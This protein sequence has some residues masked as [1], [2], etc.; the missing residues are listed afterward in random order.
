MPNYGVAQ[1]GGQLTCV[2]PGDPF[3]LFNA[4]TPTP[5]QASVAFNRGN[6]PSFDDAGTTFQISWATAPTATLDSVSIQGSNDGVHW[7]TLYTSAA[8]LQQDNF[9]D[10]TRWQFYRALLNA[11][12]T[13]GAL[14]V[15]VQR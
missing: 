8:G 2:Y 3:Y 9:T 15:L 6:S 13:G 1:I 10:I 12:S 5:P 14:T 11:E 7:Q 4:E